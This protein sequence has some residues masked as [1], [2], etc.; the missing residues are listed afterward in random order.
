MQGKIPQDLAD[1]INAFANSGG[2]KKVEK[3]LTMIEKLCAQA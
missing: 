2:A 3:D 1:R